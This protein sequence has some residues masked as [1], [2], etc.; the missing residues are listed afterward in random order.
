MD[1]TVVSLLCVTCDI[2]VLGSETCVCVV[3]KHSCQSMWP[4]GVRTNE[5]MYRFARLIVGPQALLEDYSETRLPEH[6][7]DT[8][9]YVS[10]GGCGDGMPLAALRACVPDMMTELEAFASERFRVGRPQVAYQVGSEWHDTWYDLAQLS[11]SNC[12]CKMNL[13]GEGSAKI[14]RSLKPDCQAWATG[15]FFEAAFM[16]ALQQNSEQPG[17]GRSVYMSKAFHALLN[18]QRHSANHC[19]GWHHDDGCSYGPEDPIT[20]MSWGATGVLLIKSQDK[21][22]PVVKVLVTLP[23]DVYILGGQFQQKFQH[24]VPPVREWQHILDQHKAELLPQEILAMEAEIRAQHIH[25]CSVACQAPQLRAGVRYHI[26]VRWHAKHYNCAPVW[27]LHG[28]PR[29][30]Y[31]NAYVTS[32]NDTRSGRRRQD[33]VDIDRNHIQRTQDH[34]TGQERGDRSRDRGGR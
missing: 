12:T 34:G 7:H 30:I 9:L 20:G 16:T 18:R 31:E 13:G 1:D 27:M 24:A 17:V 29:N 33:R 26:N 23:G 14:R 4:N 28:I 15:R 11:K 8:F 25:E 19:I 5:D 32:S 21:A 6:R 22:N 2:S 10:R 3:V